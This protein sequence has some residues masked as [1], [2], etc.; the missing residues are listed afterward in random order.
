MTR[1]ELE[2]HW[3]TLLDRHNSQPAEAVPM[4]AYRC[5]RCGGTF[6]R[7]TGKPPPKQCPICFCYHWDDP[8]AKHRKRGA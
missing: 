3:Q 7:A 4:T 8:K 5:G 2:A 1:E 6:E